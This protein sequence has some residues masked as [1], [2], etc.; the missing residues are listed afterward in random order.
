MQPRLLFHDPPSD[1][2]ILYGRSLRSFQDVIDKGY[3]VITFGK[4]FSVKYFKTAPEKSAMRW[5]YEN[6]MLKDESALTKDY[7]LL[8]DMV[9]NEPKTL[10]YHGY[11]VYQTR[12]PRWKNLVGLDV[13][14]YANFYVSMGFQKN[15]EYIE[16]IDHCII[17]MQENGIRDRFL[18]RWMHINDQSYG[19]SEPV[20]LDFENLIFPFMV[21]L[22]GVIAAAQIVL[23][24]W[25]LKKCTEGKILKSVGR[26]LQVSY[27]CC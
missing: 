26:S 4:S 18:K 13:E 19:I 7:N 5:V 25:V 11:G 21:L 15:S 8:L 23:M 20:T 22:L 3:R 24:E 2:Y 17:K 10:L 9:N 1:A 14:E 16:L 6:M 12:E 27:S